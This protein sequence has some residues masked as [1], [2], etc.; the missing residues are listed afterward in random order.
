[1]QIGDKVILKNNTEHYNRGDTLIITGVDVPLNELWVDDGKLC[2]PDKVKMADVA[3]TPKVE[4]EPLQF[5]LD[6]QNYASLLSVL[7]R[8]YE[9]AAAGKGKERHAQDQP[10]DEQ[11]MQTISKLVG[12]A[13]GMAYQAIKKIQESQRLPTTERQVAELL[14]AIV[15]I[16]GMVVYLEG[17]R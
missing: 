6:D 2:C 1:M 16:A 8:A 3:L 5:D 13:D 9:Q 17:E 14:G 4:P 7:G 11:P 10:F 15:Y 12:S